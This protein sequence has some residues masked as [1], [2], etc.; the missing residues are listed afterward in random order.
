MADPHLHDGLESPSCAAG[1]ASHTSV[2]H[3]PRN[4]LDKATAQSNF[5]KRSDKVGFERRNLEDINEKK[6][7]F[8][9]KELQAFFVHSR[10]RLEKTQ[11]N[12]K[13]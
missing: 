7:K 10:F 6:H 13:L 3:G 12:P 9:A 2:V 1:F 8:V 4:H 11:P 5:P